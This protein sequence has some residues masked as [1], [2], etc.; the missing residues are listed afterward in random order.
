M[1]RRSERPSVYWIPRWVARRRSRKE[2]DYATWRFLTAMVALPL[3]WGLEILIV[4][5]LAG[6][7][8]AAVFAVSLPISGV[9]AYRY[10]VGAGRF[11]S[12]LRLVPWPWVAST[13]PRRLD[14]ASGTHRRA[15]AG[16]ER[17]PRRDDRKLL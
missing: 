2:T 4:A 1:A 6:H 13:R 14:R 15:R 17:L 16:Q 12:R 8:A 5:R 11:R 7:A 3:F 10:W 9:I